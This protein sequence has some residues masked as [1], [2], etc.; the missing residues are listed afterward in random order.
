MLIRKFIIRSGKTPIGYEG[1]TVNFS[2]ERLLGWARKANEM[3]AAGFDIPAPPLHDERAVPH[4][5]GVLLNSETNA[6]DNLGFWRR[7]E[8]QEE[9]D[10]EGEKC[11]ALYGIIDAEGSKDDPESPAGKLFKRIKKVSIRTYDRFVDEAKKAWDDVIVHVAPC[12]HPALQNQKPFEELTGEHPGLAFSVALAAVGASEEVSKSDFGTQPKD[13]DK[14]DTQPDEEGE[15]LDDAAL[16]AEISR[17][18]KFVQINVK[19]TEECRKFL[20]NLNIALDQIAPEQLPGMNDDGSAAVDDKNLVARKGERM[21]VGKTDKPEEA[22]V[23]AKPETLPK[24]DAE[25]IAGGIRLSVAQSTLAPQIRANCKQRLDVLRD[26]GLDKSVADEVET[27]IGSIKGVSLSVAENSETGEYEHSLTEAEKAL[28]FIEKT[29]KGV[30]LSASQVAG[31][32]G[33]D[34]SISNPNRSNEMSDADF[35]K[36]LDAYFGPIGGSK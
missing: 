34:G 24:F 8:T 17:K 1:A 23:D 28:D 19:P 5:S 22:V 6:F 11:L 16:T 33:P 4:R 21:N 9:L 13:S 30:K 29:M 18:L 2:R 36:E 12:L 25:K 20:E 15:E 14:D 35:D 27:L 31:A 10:E 26:N 3:L 32:R 7:F